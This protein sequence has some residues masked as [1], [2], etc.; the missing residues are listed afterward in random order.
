M[1]VFVTRKMGSLSPN[2][3]SQRDER[4]SANANR[5][6]LYPSRD[7]SGDYDVT[8]CEVMMATLYE[9]YQKLNIDGSAVGLARGESESHYFCTPKGA[10]VIGWAGADG[11]HYCFVRGFGEMVFAISPMNTPG[12]YVHPVARDF[13][14][15]LRLL[16][17]CG[18][19][20][21]LEQVYLWDQTQF[22]AFLQDNSLAAEQQAILDDVR[23]ELKLVPMAQP[24]AYIKA[25]QAEFD[26]TRINYTDD[27]YECVPVESK[28]PEWKVYFEGNFWG[29]PGRER[30]GKEIVLDKQFV[31][32]EEV[33]QIPSIYICSKG[34]VIDFCVKVPAERIRSF[35]DKW[36][37]SV[38]S[39]GA[40]FSDEQ[41]MQIESENPLSIRINPKITL[42]GMD[43]T[44]AHGCGVSWNPCFQ[45]GN[46]LAAKSVLEHYGL[47]S[48]DGWAVWRAAFPWM[49]KRKSLIE[50]LSVTLRQEPMAVLGPHFNTST[51][52]ECFDFT[53]PTI[54]VQHTLTVQGY[55]RQTI[56]HE[57]FGCQNQ[58]FPTH[59]IV[60]RYKL[61][62]DLPEGAFTITD[63]LRS[64][65]PRQKR[66]SINESQA[67]NSVCI[68]IIGGADGQAAIQISGS[69]QSEFRTACSALHFEPV[70]EVEWRI[71][72]YEKRRD[73]VTVVLI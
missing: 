64:D 44:F 15:F 72:F 2:T 52:G 71:V 8:P 1:D 53:H 10:K 27:Y 7:P 68:G 18:D 16:L 23:D 67:D 65:R 50:T 73:D 40:G 43:Q 46:N 69:G 62:P 20:A 41:R 39:D 56:D 21:A 38:E 25:L 12:N 30:A 59:F 34:L 45:E 31:W 42:N 4:R 33:W 60:M 3:S 55:E 70:G 37:L 51:P 48:T 17:A 14:D 36:K 32:G 57:H 58:E 5:Q 47:D 49:K 54:G 13:K 9:R 26:Y 24:F 35:V 61:S 63:C 22:D 11:I 28:I 6:C 29:H 19:A 66:G